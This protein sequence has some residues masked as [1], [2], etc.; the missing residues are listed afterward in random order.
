[1][2]AMKKEFGGVG[3]KKL[4]E[5]ILKSIPYSGSICKE[6]TQDSITYGTR[7]FY[8][9]AYLSCTHHKHHKGH[10]SC[11]I[12]ELD[13]GETITVFDSKAAEYLAALLVKRI[14]LA[15]RSQFELKR[16]VNGFKKCKKLMGDISDIDRIQ[17]K[18]K[19][20]Q[21]TLEIE[22]PI[23]LVCFKQRSKHGQEISC[24]QPDKKVRRSSCRFT[25]PD[26]ECDTYEYT[27]DFEGRACWDL[28]EERLAE[29]E[30]KEAELK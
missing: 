5:F 28:L 29:L 6:E 19:A 22:A 2:E 18:E 30:K 3:K 27:I 12:T 7:L 4:G 26:M 25:N 24:T 20:G 13:T 9:H 21:E 11:T 17:K 1:M 15:G 10:D 16:R 23:K 14:D 8:V